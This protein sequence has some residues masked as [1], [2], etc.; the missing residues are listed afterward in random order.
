MRFREVSN[1]VWKTTRSKWYW[2]LALL[3]VSALLFF[4]LGIKLA[5]GVFV[6]GIVAIVS[7]KPESFFA[8]G[9]AVSVLMGVFLTARVGWLA[10]DVAKIAFALMAVGTLLGAWSLWTTAEVEEGKPG[11][12]GE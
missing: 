7:L 3:V 10:L 2:I 9:I 11:D 12:E 6:L 1:A 8:V 5:I 4:L